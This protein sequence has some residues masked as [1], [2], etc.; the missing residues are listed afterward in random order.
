MQCRSR[1]EDFKI[2]FETWD[3]Q[4]WGLFLAY[5]TE[6]YD[7]LVQ[8]KKLLSLDKPVSYPLRLVGNFEKLWKFATNTELSGT[9]LRQIRSMVTRKRDYVV[10]GP[11][12]LMWE[13]LRAI[14]TCDFPVLETLLPRIRIQHGSNKLSLQNLRKEDRKIN[15]NNRYFSPKSVVM[16][17]RFF[18][19]FNTFKT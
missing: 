1:E 3:P 4:R 10:E 11:H 14:Y 5:C 2:C 6:P 19:N 7:K 9:R 17:C 13:V 18:H 15:G 12:Q 16:F 8:D